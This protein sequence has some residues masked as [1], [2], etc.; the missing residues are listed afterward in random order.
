MRALCLLAVVSATAWGQQLQFNAFDGV[1]ETPI[2]NNVL[3][4]PGPFTVGVQQQIRI[5]VRNRTGQLACI[6][7]NPASLGTG[8]SLD[9]ANPSLP[10]TLANDA[11]IDFKVDFL[12]PAIARSASANFEIPRC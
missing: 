1:N 5:R 3:S 12:P 8:F 7:R 9:P 4:L 11:A 6:V 2:P 10:A